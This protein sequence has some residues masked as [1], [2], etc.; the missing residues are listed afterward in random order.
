MF[1]GSG[2]GKLP[3]ASAVVADMVDMAKHIDKNIFVRW[4]KEKLE[5]ADSDEGV[6]S[7]FVR[8]AEKPEKI[9]GI[10]GQVEFVDAG[11]SGETG[12]V[13]EAMTEKE[14]KK[15][16]GLLENVIQMIRLA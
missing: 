13:T 16:A 12:F 11:I 6:C 1:Y 10:F 4:D 8:T 15:K 3:T 7:F 14:Y 9:S 5:L 2:A